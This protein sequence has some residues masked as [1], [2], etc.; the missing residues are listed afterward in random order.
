MF[1]RA[2]FSSQIASITDMAVTIVLTSFVNIYYVVGTFIGA[3][4]GGIV[5]CV[6]NYKWTFKAD[7]VKKK[8]V[9]AKYI[10]VWIG[11]ILLNTLGTYLLTEFLDRSTWVIAHFSC[12]LEYIYIFAK[13]FVS[14]MV[15][16]IWN[17]NL[18]RVFVYRN[19][20]IKKHFVKNKK[21][22]NKIEKE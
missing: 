4:C 12:I 18:Q 8:H 2:Q 17:Y 22:N 5:N 6:I 21:D 13:L 11:S 1:I 20:E 14:L 9:V 3:V 15:G 10:L 19:I 7:G 16:F